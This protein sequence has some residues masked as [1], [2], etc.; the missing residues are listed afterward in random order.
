MNVTVGPDFAPYDNS[1]KVLVTV[2]PEQAVPW[3]L[4]LLGL[5]VVGVGG[6]AI[7]RAVRRAHAFYRQRRVLRSVEE[8]TERWGQ[9]VAGGRRDASESRRRRVLR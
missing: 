2:V 7:S 3:I 5:L 1:M 4:L 9:E 8:W 6:V